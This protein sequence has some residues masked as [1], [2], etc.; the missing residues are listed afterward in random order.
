MVLAI[1]WAII[2]SHSDIA[3]RFWNFILETLSVVPLMFSVNV[4]ED[5]NLDDVVSADVLPN[6]GDIAGDLSQDL[7]LDDAGDLVS[8]GVLSSVEDLS[9]VGDL[10]NIGDLPGDDVLP[11]NGDLSVGTD[12]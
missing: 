1:L 6:V 2:L 3:S 5:V 4:A 7:N 9:N 12:L 11:L 10:P 8:V